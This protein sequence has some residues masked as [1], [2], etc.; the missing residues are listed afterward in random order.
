[1]KK[2]IMLIFSV[3]LVIA[4]SSK[5]Q[6]KEEQSAKSE[7]HT[8]KTME[9]EVIT[10]ITPKE[11]GATLFDAMMNRV[12]VREYA[13]VGLTI[14]QLSGILWATSGQNRPDGKHT[15]PS[16]M[17]LYPIMVYA[18]LPNGIYLYNSKEHKLTLVKKGDHR[19]MAGT[20][21]FVYTAQLNLMYVSDLQRFDERKPA[22]PTDDE[23][24]FVSA[25]DA[26]HYSQ[27]A[28]LWA[29]ANGMGSVPRGWT[30]EEE[31]LKTISAPDSYRVVLAQTFGILK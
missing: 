27:S 18:V 3:A 16:A 2:Y 1:M 9:T 26:G 24:L 29:A 30:N 15:T 7:E 6:N 14:E 5:A 31:F 4:C 25:L 17:G 13:E 12:S 10:L 8:T 20:Q 11:T 22:Y 21:E 28:A 19:Q 23:R